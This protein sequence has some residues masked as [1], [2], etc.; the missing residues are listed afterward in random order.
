[1]DERID[2]FLFAI[3]S[4]VGASIVEAGKGPGAEDDFAEDQAWQ[5]ARK[6]L[7]ELL[8]EVLK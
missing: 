3:R 8:D 6:R 1:M 2:E 7:V 5:H 4:A